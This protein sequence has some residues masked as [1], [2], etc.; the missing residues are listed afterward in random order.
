[1]KKPP[2]VALVV[3]GSFSESPLA[4]ASGLVDSLGPVKASSLRLASRIAN[5][6]P[7][8]R[9]VVD[10]QEF[11]ACPVVLVN[12]PDEMSRAIISE[13]ALAG[14]DWT[15]KVVVLCSNR[16]GV[17]ELSRLGQLGAATGSLAV[18][19]GFESQWYLLEG[20]KSVER[21]IRPMLVQRGVRVTMIASG[22]KARYASALDAVG[23]ELGP[24]LKKAS[25]SLKIAGLANAEALAILENQLLSTL[26]SYFRSGKF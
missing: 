19:S 8:G 4:R 6:L 15:G 7:A 21:Q 24:V 26:R 10:Y 2:R 23:S 11:E 1:M 22:E 14:I 12:V 18:V 17:A 20:E 9:A 3:A 16:L 5:K 13:M 25:D